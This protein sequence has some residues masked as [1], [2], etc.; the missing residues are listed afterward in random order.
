MKSFDR[1]VLSLSKGMDGIHWFRASFP[2]PDA[3][4]DHPQGSYLLA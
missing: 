3:G 1:P 2:Y 4:D